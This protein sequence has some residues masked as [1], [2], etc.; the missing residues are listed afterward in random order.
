VEVRGVDVNFSNWDNGLEGSTLRLGLRQIDGFREAWAEPITAARPFTSI[1]QLAR[2][3]ALPQAALRMLADADALRS[4]GKDR[5]EGLWEVRR[6]P[7]D[8]LPLFAAARAR[9]L[10]QEAPVNLPEMPLAAHVAA[11]YQTLRLSLK[12]HPM[13][14]LRPTFAAEHI[15]SAAQ[16]ALAKNGARLR[17]AGVVLV[18]QRPGKGNAIFITLEDETGIVNVV[19]WARRFEVYRRQVMAARLMEVAGE[20]QRSPEGVLHLM[21]TRIVDRTAELAH[22]SDTH[23]LAPQLS[24]ADIIAH[25]RVPE[26]QHTDEAYNQVPYPRASHPRDVRVLPKSRDFH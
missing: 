24:R 9:E 3:T 26:H 23:A 6:T 1:E 22:L 13:A 19:L 14:L 7:S 21:A 12:A 2:A 16:V 18:R 25:P 5:R 17:M 10:A 4:L 20:L 11:D 15:S 8:E